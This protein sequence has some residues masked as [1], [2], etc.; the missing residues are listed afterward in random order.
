MQLTI[1]NDRTIEDLN[2][3]FMAVFPYLKIHFFKN[4][5]KENQ[6]SPKREILPVTTKFKMI[7]HINGVVIISED[8]TVKEVEQFFKLHFNLNAQ[9]FRKSGNNWLETTITDAWTL[10][11]QN[12]EG[13]ELSKLAG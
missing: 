3:D 4:T 11:K 2:Q 8:H 10:K 13:M 9:L 12:Q 1:N 7:N 6:G 5:H